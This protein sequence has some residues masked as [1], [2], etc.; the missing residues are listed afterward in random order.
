MTIRQLTQAEID[1]I[2]GGGVILFSPQQTPLDLGV[3]IPSDYLKPEEANFMDRI[4]QE[5]I[6]AVIRVTQLISRRMEQ[7]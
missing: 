7:E 2:F 4:S 1:E 6:E 3:S 5:E